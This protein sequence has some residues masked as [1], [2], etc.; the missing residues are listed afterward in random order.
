[1]Y[2]EMVDPGHRWTLIGEGE[3][4]RRGLAVKPRSNCRLA[5]GRLEG[6]GVR[7]LGVGE[8]VRGVM[9]AYGAALMAPE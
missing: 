4:V 9:G 5:S 6:L 7:M 3:L 2:R 8:A 1:M